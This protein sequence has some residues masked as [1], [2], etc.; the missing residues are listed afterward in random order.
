M[1]FLSLRFYVK[2]I[3]KESKSA[4]SAILTHLEALNFDLCEFLHFL[5]AEIAKIGF[6]ELLRSSKLISRKNLKNKESSDFHT[7]M[8]IH[9]HGKF[10]HFWIHVTEIVV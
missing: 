7:V 10:T 2:S 5:N 6:F 4:K 9:F 1:I 3:F 8:K